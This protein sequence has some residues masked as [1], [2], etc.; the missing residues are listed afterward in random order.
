MAQ[1]KTIERKIEVEV[2]ETERF[3]LRDGQ[4]D[5]IRAALA[6][7]ADLQASG[8]RLDELTADDV[9][10]EI[11]YDASFMRDN[12][13]LRVPVEA[14]REPVISWQTV[15]AAAS[16]GETREELLGTVTLEQ[17]H[18]LRSKVNERISEVENRL[19]DESD[20]LPRF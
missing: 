16:R 11:G 18:N 20:H 4:K 13:A 15:V 9:E 2:L 5:V 7:A 6:A 1:K 17:L 8:V 12:F 19:R 10:I 3:L 14:G